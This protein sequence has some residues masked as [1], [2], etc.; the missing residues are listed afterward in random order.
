M[1]EKKNKKHH[2]KCDDHCECESIHNHHPHVSI[3]K[4]ITKVP[5][6]LAEVTLQVNVDTIITFP[7]L[8]LEIKDIKKRLKITQCRLLLPTNK[9]FVKG[10]VRKNIQYASP[11]KDISE[12]NPTSVASD[13]HSLTVDIPF[14][15]VTE[16]KK[17]LSNPVM[18]ETND[19]REFDFFVSKPLP[20]GFPEKDELLTSDLSQ[21]HQ[22]SKQFYNELPFCELISSKII[23][24]DEAIDREPLPV[25]S[26]L[27]EGVFTKIEEKMVVDFTLKVLQN[28]QVRISSTTNDH[29]WDSDCD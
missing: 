28:Q 18:P 22:E 8:V 16:I 11:C 14:Q 24:W 25:S 6:V 13:L 26:P 1:S 10:F 29:D 19:R 23:E 20:S 3:G 15:C 2:H 5:V 7:E 27:D 12:S 17:F 21:F 9:L 4:L